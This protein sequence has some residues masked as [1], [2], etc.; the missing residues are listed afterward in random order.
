MA[1]AYFGEAV[2]FF[3]QPGRQHALEEAFHHER[4]ELS[5][6]GQVLDTK[7]QDGTYASGALP[8]GGDIGQFL[9]AETFN[10]P[11]Q[12]VFVLDFDFDLVELSLPSG[13][14]VRLNPVLQ[15]S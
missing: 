6:P 9:N 7:G 8:C 4:R 3:A 5:T 14:I 15:L 10:L 2:T 11:Q 12:R 13:T 1:G